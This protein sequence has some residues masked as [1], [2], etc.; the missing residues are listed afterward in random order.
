MVDFVKKKAIIL[1]SLVFVCVYLCGC[2][3]ESEATNLNNEKPDSIVAACEMAYEKVDNLDEESDFDVEGIYLRSED[4]Y[5]VMYQCVD[6]EQEK[7]VNEWDKAAIEETL[8]SAQKL[9]APYFDGFDVEVFT[10]AIDTNGDPM[11][12]YIEEGMFVDERE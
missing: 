10:G 8:G 12:T 7:I 1:A 3:S 9:I 4:S 2:Q 11:I 6:E 5:I